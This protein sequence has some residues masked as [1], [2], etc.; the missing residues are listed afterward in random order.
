MP[1][2]VFLGF[3]FG[4]KRIGVAVGQAITQTASPLPT[5]KAEQGKPDW[6]VIQSIIKKW[7]PEALIVGLPTDSS[8]ESLSV[9]KPT[10]VFA[11]KLK[12]CSN[13]PV[14][15]VD[16]RL[17]TMEARAKLFEKGGYKKI[18]SAAIDGYAATLILEQWLQTTR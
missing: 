3:D 11:A 2:G 16:E 6:N 10:R 17:T 7:H 12:A 9:T 4:L 15:L 13:L 14:H 18:K 1:E 5:I 8:G